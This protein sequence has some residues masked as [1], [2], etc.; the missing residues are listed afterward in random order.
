MWSKKPNHI[1]PWRT[2]PPPGHM[3]SWAAESSLMPFL[4]CPAGFPAQLSCRHSSQGKAEGKHRHGCVRQEPFNSFRNSYEA[5]SYFDLLLQ[6]TQLSLSS[7]S[8]WRS[9]WDY[10][11]GANSCGFSQDSPHT[12]RHVNAWKKSAV[13]PEHSVTQILMLTAQLGNSLSLKFWVSRQAS[14]WHLQTLP[15]LSI[16]QLRQLALTRP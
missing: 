4:V 3:S 2:C 1:S 7:I 13:C 9:W 16:N 12:T 8:S 11:H 5:A 14:C 10:R 6:S 15:I